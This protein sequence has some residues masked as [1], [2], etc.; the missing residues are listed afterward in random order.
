MIYTKA[1]IVT[2]EVLM[3]VENLMFVKPYLKYKSSLSL[4]LSSD[5]LSFT[6]QIIVLPTKTNT[7]SVKTYFGE[8]FLSQK[9]S[10]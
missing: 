6:N 2:A 5:R 9:E 7:Q 8:G 1:T 4:Q 3:V 10:W